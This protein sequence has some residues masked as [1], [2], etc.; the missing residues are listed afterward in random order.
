MSVVKELER[1][2][3]AAERKAASYANR[4]DAFVSNLE[5]ILLEVEFPKLKPYKYSKKKKI[6]R[7][8]NL[9]QSDLHYGSDLKVDE[10]PIPYGTVEERRRTA[11]LAREV[12]EYKPHYRD[13][14]KAII[15]LAGDIIQGRLHDLADAAPVAEQVTRAIYLQGALIARVAEHYPEVEVYCTPGNHGRIKDRHRDRAVAQ[16]WDSF[17]NIIYEALRIKF[18]DVKNIK[19]HIPKTPFYEYS[20]FGMRGFIT[21]GDTVLNPGYPGKAINVAKLENQVMKLKEARGNYQLVGVGHVH[22]PSVIQ[23]PSTTLVTNGC[24]IPPD[25][26]AVSIG[27]HNNVTAQQLWETVP[28]YMMGDHRM[29][30]VNTETDKDS[31]LDKLIPPDAR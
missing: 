19:F 11:A 1:K 18:L 20:L 5:D 6:Q 9:L 22:V 8:V 24:L 12:I 30:N 21:H 28:G 15:H 31:S 27:F 17:E 16:K 4:T 7:V 14:T 13:E 2:L 23:L 3:A 25:A 10:V 29:I 26:Y